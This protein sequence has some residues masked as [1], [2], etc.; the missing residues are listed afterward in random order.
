MAFTLIK[1]F[2]IAATLEA[3][4]IGG[5]RWLWSRRLFLHDKVGSE[6]IARGTGAKIAT[7]HDYRGLCG[8]V[9]GAPLEAA[10][11]VS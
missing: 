1:M 4:G 11:P 3:V 6:L 5:V 9:P 10:A 7:T 8:R 2:P